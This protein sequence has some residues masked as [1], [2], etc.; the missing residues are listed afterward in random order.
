LQGLEVSNLNPSIPY[1]R[2]NA[3]SCLSFQMFLHEGLP[4]SV[5]NEFEKLGED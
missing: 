5:Q 1:Q 4:L 3:R 2:L